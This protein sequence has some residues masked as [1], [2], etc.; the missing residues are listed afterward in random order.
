[1]VWQLMAPHYGNDSWAYTLTA[2]VEET[3]ETIGIL[4]FCVALSWYIQELCPKVFVAPD[5]TGAGPK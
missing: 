1:M 5:V 4:G 2:G 3:L